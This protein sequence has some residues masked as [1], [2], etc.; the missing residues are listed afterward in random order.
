MSFLILKK[1]YDMKAIGWFIRNMQAIPIAN[2]ND[3]TAY[4]R[5]LKTLKEGKC[6]TIYPEGSRSHDGELSK[7]Q[8]GP[9]RVALASGATI[10]PV[11]I[12]GA[13]EVWP[14]NKSFP[15]FFKKIVIKFHPPIQYKPVANKAEMREQ[16]QVINQKLET[17]LDRNLRAWQ[18]LRNR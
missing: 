12:L 15:K 17:I 7:I 16:V 18:K 5:I 10:I 9:A 6:I 3:R 11:S 13:Y 14:R 4:L 2:G 8:A 1:Y